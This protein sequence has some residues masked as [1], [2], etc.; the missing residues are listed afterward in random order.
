MSDSVSKLNQQENGT[1]F[2]EG[3][4]NPPNVG[5]FD[6]N[7]ANTDNS[8]SSL[9]VL[10]ANNCSINM[11]KLMTS[12][13]DADDY[14]NNIIRGDITENCGTSTV[15]SKNQAKLLGDVTVV[16]ETYGSNEGKQRIA[17]HMNYLLC[18]LA[19]ARNRVYDSSKFDIFNSSLSVKEIFNK[20]A[21]IKTVMMLIF[22]LSIYFLIQGFFSSFDVASNMVNLIE[23]NSSKSI[24]YYVSLAA[25]IAI[26]V[27][28]L[29]Y[30]FVK[31][32]CGYLED[33]EKYDITND[34]NGK[35][36]KIPSG[37]KGLDYS[38]LFLF[39]VLIYGFVFVLF[40]VTKES[41]GPLMYIITIGF[42]F[43]IISVF[44]YLFYTYIPF[45]ATADTN[46]VNKDDLDLKLYIDYQYDPSNISSN[47]KQIQKVQTVFAYTAI[48]IFV[49]FVIYIIYSKFQKD[50]KGM[51][52]D[53]FSGFFGASAILIIPIIWVLNFILATKYFYIYPIILLGF[54]FLRYIFMAV[55]YGQYSYAQEYGTEGVLAGDYYS[56]DLKEQ[57]EDFS[58]Y[59]PSYN[60]LGMD[61]IK[62]LLNIF[63]Y[64]NI[65]SKSYVN[66]NKHNNLAANRYV[67]PGLFSYLAKDKDENEDKTSNK[68][69]I[70]FSIF[71]ITIFVTY[72]LLFKVYKV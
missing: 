60:L 54:R 62:T 66:N 22:L 32:V 47:Q 14:Y 38:V 23:E 11:N 9:K 4:P 44:L 19:S 21:N 68:L 72:I 51:V 28:I 57:L 34:I 10:L 42:I 6:Q 2:V 41:L 59:S 17:N 24:I 1:P 39:M 16:L 27:L 58:N 65:F 56:D 69:K 8:A 37:F 36:E 43:F 63:G 12:K 25:G 61:V 46:N 29:C 48:L 18:Q 30:F 35:K 15:S 49:F 40:S 7:K 45:F 31:K 52:K 55:L 20:F 5:Y 71:S 67:I 70:Q 53:I 50:N 33:I 64:E 13:E 3:I 26:P